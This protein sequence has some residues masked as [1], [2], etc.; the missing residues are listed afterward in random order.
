MIQLAWKQKHRNMPQRHNHTL[1]NTGTHRH[2][3][4]LQCLSLNM[5]EKNEMKNRVSM[6]YQF[7][8]LPSQNTTVLMSKSPWSPCQEI[9]SLGASFFGLQMA[10]FLLGS[11]MIFPLYVYVPLVSLCVSKFPLLI[12]KRKWQVIA[13]KFQGEE[14]GGLLSIT[15]QRVGHH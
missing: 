11:Y 13:G 3:Y 1:I 12:R 5:K 7:L 10:V 9:W 6:V 4:D 2:S 8:G 15:S 14:P